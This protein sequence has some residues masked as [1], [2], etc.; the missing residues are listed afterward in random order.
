MEHE[1]IRLKL[2]AYLDNAVSDVDKVEIKKHL[3]MCGACRGEIADLELTVKY[4]KSL[5]EIEPP[6]WLTQKVM[7]KVSEEDLNKKSLWH[8][9][10]FPLHVKL[11]IEAL[12]I[13]VLCVLAYN[14]TGPKIEQAN[15]AEQRRMPLPTKT[16]PSPS[17]EMESNGNPPSGY[18]KG[19][20]VFNKVDRYPSDMDI[21][22]P[23]A[24]LPAPPQKQESPPPQAKAQ[25]RRSV[26]PELQN[27]DSGFMSD[28]EL[29][30]G[31]KE[32]KMQVASRVAKKG[33][34][35]SPE[36]GLSAVGALPIGNAEITLEVENPAT[37]SAAI[38][39]AVTKL[40][41]RINGHSSS[42]NSYFL[43]IRI[44]T[45]KIKKLADRLSRIGTIKEAPQTTSDAGGLTDV[46]IRW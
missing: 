31:S 32:E 35:A 7:A 45:G 16:R 3:G 4:L 27:V 41:G 34:T 23:G 26:E 25:P 21:Q 36:K 46:T 15:L 38:E 43:S 2:A 22:Q 42:G 8:R 40:G 19:K 13:V 29:A 39:D 10:F 20:G 1:E 18:S 33:K 30:S 28:R 17:N 44:S 5:P 9:L 14:L 6:S 37:A 11:P 12:T 24:A